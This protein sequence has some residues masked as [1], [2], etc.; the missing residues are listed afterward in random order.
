MLP[1]MYYKHAFTCSVLFVPYHLNLSLYFLIDL[2]ISF[3]LDLFTWHHIMENHTFPKTTN[4]QYIYTL[5][6]WCLHVSSFSAILFIIQDTPEFGQDNLWCASSLFLFHC[7]HLIKKQMLKIQAITQTKLEIC[8]YILSMT[9]YPLIFMLPY[10]DKKAKNNIDGTNLN[11]CYA[12][13]I[14]PHLL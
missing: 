14:T 12:N 8:C 10:N 9:E 5:H 7:Y 1:N 11:C 13:S 3:V 2:H 4:H 6:I